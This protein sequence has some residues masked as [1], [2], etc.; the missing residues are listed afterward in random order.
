[1]K[2]IGTPALAVWQAHVQ[3]LFDHDELSR[4][5]RALLR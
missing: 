2:I 4:H 1:M 5:L 3:L